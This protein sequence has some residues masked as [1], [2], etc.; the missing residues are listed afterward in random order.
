MAIERV[1]KS[2]PGPI[3]S[4][5]ASDCL[6]A[7]A[8]FETLAPERALVDPAIFSPGKGHPVMLQLDDGARSFAAHVMDGVLVAE[9][10]GAFDGV[11]RVPSPIVFGHVSQ[12]PRPMDR[13][14]QQT[15][16]R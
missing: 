9:P 11:I 3:G 5:G 2:V 4:R 7:L 1:E 14:Q 8:E 16:D 10:V 6:A 13:T 15:P 12:R